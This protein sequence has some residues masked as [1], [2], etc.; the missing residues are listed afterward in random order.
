MDQGFWEEIKWED[1]SKKDIESCNIFKGGIHTKKMK[2]ISL[3]QRRERGSKGVYL[4]V[5]KRELYLTIKVTT[6]CTGVLY[7]KEG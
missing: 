1:G 2:N 3:I 6:D 5:D 7:R 4:E